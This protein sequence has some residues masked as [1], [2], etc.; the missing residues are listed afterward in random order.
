MSQRISY[1]PLSGGLDYTTAP[2]FVGPGRALFIK[3]YACDLNGGYRQLGQYER[4][5]GRTAPSSSSDPAQQEIYRALITAVPGSGP[6]RGVAYFNG[7][8]YAWRDNAGGTAT[9]MHKSTAGGWVAITAAS[10]IPFNLGNTSTAIVEGNT[11]GNAAVPTKT[12]VVVRVVYYGVW[13]AT[14]TATGRLYVTSVVGAWAAA[15]PIY[16]GATQRATATGGVTT[17]TIAPAGQYETIQFNFYGASDK[18]RLYGVDGVNPAFDFDGTYLCHYT[19]GMAVDKPTH[20]AQNH[21]YLWLTFPGGSL[22]NSAVGD[23]TGFS[24]RLGS[25]EISLGEDVTNLLAQKDTTV[26]YGRNSVFI[27]YG[28]DASSFQLKSFTRQGGAISRTAQ[29]VG[30]EVIA[31]DDSGLLFLQA[32]QA[33]GDFGAATVSDQVRPVFDRQTPSFTVMQRSNGRYYLF[34]TD[35]TALVCTLAGTKVLGYGNAGYA[36]QFVCGWSGEDTG[37]DDRTFVGSDNGFIYELDKGDSQ[38]GAAIESI[39]RLPFNALQGPQ[40]RKRWHKLRLD[41]ISPSAVT[42]R[43]APEFD[44]GITSDIVQ[45][46]AFTGGGGYWDSVAW[47]EFTWDGGAASDSSI[48]L[49]GVSPNIGFVIYHN[50]KT[51]SF[52]LVAVGLSW[53]PRSQDRA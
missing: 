7:T 4:F 23:P 3:N 12:A 11:I 38:D 53:T 48:Y 49:N 26:C 28:N 6:V 46:A 47:D 41:I 44:Y 42:L 32:V 13:D 34:W 20:L 39:I 22:Q 43:V 37:G 21:N 25:A 40:N 36:H 2:L 52:A 27:L 10:Y 9:V 18:F 24:P 15:D 29:Y 19:T 8:V 35:K 17:Q 14:T 31:L 50:E 16:V 30:S 5:D 45:D 51:T 33:Y 1:Y